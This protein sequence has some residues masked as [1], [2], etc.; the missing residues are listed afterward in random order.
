MTSIGFWALS[1]S[2]FLFGI[3]YLILVLA[4]LESPQSKMVGF[5]YKMDWMYYIFEW[6]IDILFYIAVILFLM[7]LIILVRKTN[8][9][10]KN[11][12]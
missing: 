6:M 12:C 7:R 4:F 10:I 11:K 3:K 8:L 1:A 9:K 2:T 5:L